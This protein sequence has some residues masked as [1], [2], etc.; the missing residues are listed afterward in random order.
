MMTLTYALH[1]RHVLFRMMLMTRRL[2]PTLCFH[3][4]SCQMSWAIFK[5]LRLVD[6]CCCCWS[7]YCSCKADGLHR[8]HNTENHLRNNLCKTKKGRTSSSSLWNIG[9]NGQKTF[10]TKADS[11]RACTPIKHLH[12]MNSCILKHQT[13]FSVW[14]HIMKPYENGSMSFVDVK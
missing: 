8:L 11:K 13:Q 12:N 5:T 2:S 3:L 4:K 7:C 6:T 1:L 14:F 9:R 10:I